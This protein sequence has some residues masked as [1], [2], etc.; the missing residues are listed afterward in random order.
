MKIYADSA[1]D[2]PKTFYTEN[3]VHLFPLR[4]ELNGEEFDDIIGVEPEKIYEEI[5]AGKAPKTS[6]VSPEL[7]LEAFEELAKSGEEGLYI[8]F[9]SALS[10]TYSTSMMIREQVLETYPD[11]KLTIIDTKCASIGYGLVVKEAVR[12]RDASYSFADVVKRS[13][14]N[15]EHME[16]LFTVEDLDFLARGG[17]VSKT[18][19]FI[20]GLL[21]IK[22]LLH[23]EDGKL[24]PIEKLRGR[25]KVFKRILDI[26]E[27]RGEHLAKQ[28]IGI[29]HGDDMEAAKEI[30]AMIV[31][32]F[33]PIGIEVHIVGS[34]IACHSGPGTIA[35]FFLN[36]L[37]DEEQI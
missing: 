28:V 17:R 10:G 30:K 8:A 7:F 6:Q 25:K 35:I 29:S 14:F 9:S 31:E 22:P 24:I 32:R 2:L 15:A 27:E 33:H 36:E 21:N 1:C 37:F 11:L 23:M 12:L 4:V 13:Q 16:H 26:M 5:R 20:G 3:S 34:T 18:S 19:A